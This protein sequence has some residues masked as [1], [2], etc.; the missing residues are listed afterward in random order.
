MLKTLLAHPLTR[1][2]DI[3]D[4]RTTHLRRQIIQQKGFLRQIYHE[5]YQDIAEVL[6]SGQEPVLELGAGGGFMADFVPQ[7]ITSELFYCPNIRIV[8]DGSHLPFANRSLRGVVMTDVLHHLPQPRMF[9]AEATRCVRSGGV[10]AMIEPWVTPWSRL[11][12]SRLHHE[13]FE[14]QVPSW[15][16]PTS[17]PLSGAND[18]LPWILF[19]RDRLKFEQEYPH[20][21]IE[22]IRPIMP[23]R[24]LLSGGVSL[25]SL[26]PGWS[27]G[28]WRRIERSLGRWNNQ[29]AMFAQ[30]VLRH[31]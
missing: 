14:P 31:R 3:D 7:L 2:L 13:P 30:I 23:F 4:P 10:V 27:F 1:G 28:L 8:L 11:I 25:R 26:T 15:E 5:W 24:Y 22:L 12:Y 20:W 19:V 29:L 18:A 21:E 17:G 6:P 16:L 9:F